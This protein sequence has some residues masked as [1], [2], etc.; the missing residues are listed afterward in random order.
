MTDRASVSGGSAQLSMFGD[1]DQRMANP[2]APDI[3]PDP[4][5]VRAKL[6][7][8]LDT[9]RNAQSMPWTD[10]K[11]R[12]WQIVFPQMANWLPPQ[13]ADELRLEFAQEIERLK[14]A[15]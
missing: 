11:A 4:E 13:E 9:A 15:A 3:T 8:L 10:R 6:L 14:K 12:M 7:A 2:T 5:R 1:G